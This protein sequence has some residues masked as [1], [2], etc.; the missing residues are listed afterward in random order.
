MKY[1]SR[2][3]IVSMILDSVSTGATK[4]KIMYKAYLSYTQLKEYLTY[5]ESNELLRYEQG[6]QLYRITEKGRKLMQLYEEIGEM[7]SPTNDDK[8][9]KVII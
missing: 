3:E 7:V 4:T 9:A 6:A 1:R 5:L 8:L 2:N